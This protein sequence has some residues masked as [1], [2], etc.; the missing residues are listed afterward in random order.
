MPD[1]GFLVDD[2]LPTEETRANIINL[3]TMLLAI[4]QSNGGGANVWFVNR[5]N[6]TATSYTQA[7]GGFPIHTRESV[8]EAFNEPVSQSTAD[9]NDALHH[10][11]TPFSST[12]EVALTPSLYLTVFVTK[13]HACPDRIRKLISDISQ[14]I[15]GSDAS[16]DILNIVFAQIV[17]D[18]VVTSFLTE[19]Q[20]SI[21]APGIIKTITADTIENRD[22]ALLCALAEPLDA[23]LNPGGD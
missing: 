10:I 11:L 16:R 14:K 8:V 17:T 12:E 7:Q 9:L 21:A 15:Y 13:S 1:V 4:A 23:A 20:K 6:P 22:N 19:L 5:Q 2:P 18:N 3:I